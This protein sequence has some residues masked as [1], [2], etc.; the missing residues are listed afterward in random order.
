MKNLVLLGGGYG[1]MR[2]MSRILPHSIPEGYH[3]TLIDRMPFHGLKPE[4]YALAAG[5]KSDKEVRIQFPDSSKINTVY[6]EINDIDL[7]EQMITVG[8]SKIDYDE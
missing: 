7:D 1:N 3:L 6:G 4:F 8:N 2:I 5:T